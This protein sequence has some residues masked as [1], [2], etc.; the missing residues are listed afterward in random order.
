MDRISYATIYHSIISEI[1]SDGVKVIHRKMPKGINGY[2]DCEK[3]IISISP[4][5]KCKL[6]GIAV[7]CHEWGHH[8]DFASGKFPWFYWKAGSEQ[9]TEGKL[10][11]VIKSEKSASK[12]AL[13]KLKEFGIKSY[14]Y[15]ELN[16]EKEQELV[17][18]Y[19]KYYFVRS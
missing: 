14:D 6:E 8:I 13:S 17:D 7:L 4:S 15:A 18:F 1:K 9:I 19:K 3:K 12:I 2:Y 10:A 5:I 11:K 16:Q